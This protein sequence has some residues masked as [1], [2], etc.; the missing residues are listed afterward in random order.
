[1]LL[2]ID[3]FF[4]SNVCKCKFKCEYLLQSE[5]GEKIFEYNMIHT[6]THIYLGIKKIIL[7][8][9]NIKEK[10][11]VEQISL[12]LVFLQKESLVQYVTK[13]IILDIN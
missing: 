4:L 12:T 7:Q 3:L 1:M 13:N 6:H 8:L 10:L 9:L 11:R 5:A 2:R